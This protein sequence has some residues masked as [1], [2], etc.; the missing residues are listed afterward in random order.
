MEFKD[1]NPFVRFLED[2]PPWRQALSVDINHPGYNLCKFLGDIIS[3]IFCISILWLIIG[4]LAIYGVAPW[5]MMLFGY[6]F[7]LVLSGPLIGSAS[8]IVG[9]LTIAVTGIFG[10][11]CLQDHGYKL[12]PDWHFSGKFGEAYQGVLK[13]FCP[14]VTIKKTDQ[15]E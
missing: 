5:V 9:I 6:P 1:T 4:W 8:L 12:L 14:L 11:H 13:R 2:S 7:P 10:Y 15:E 3:G